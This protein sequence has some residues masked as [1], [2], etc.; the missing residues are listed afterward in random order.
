MCHYQTL[1]KRYADAI[2]TPPYN[3]ARKLQSILRHDECEFIGNADQVGELQRRAGARY[4]AD[5]ARVL[6]AAVVDLGGFHDANAWGNPS[7]DHFTIPNSNAAT[8]AGPC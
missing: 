6:V 7:F 5:N 1:S 2:L 8:V 3:A 4:I